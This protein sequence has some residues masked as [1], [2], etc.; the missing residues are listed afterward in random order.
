MVVEEKDLQFL[1]KRVNELV[2]RLEQ[3]EEDI[4][5]V[6]FVVALFSKYMQY[7]STLNNGM[8]DKD[9]VRRAV[10]STDVE[11]QK[12]YG[13]GG[14]TDYE[15]ELIVAYLERIQAQMFELSDEERKKLR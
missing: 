14:I 13:E 12:A 2:D 1:Q 10:L 3:M 11:L 9:V 5:R 7:Y 4:E 15:E 6:T 8:T